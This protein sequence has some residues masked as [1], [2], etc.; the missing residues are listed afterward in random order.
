MS[1]K[2]RRYGP[3][4]LPAHKQRRHPVSCRLTDAE[5][6]RL[7]GLRGAVSRGEWLRLSALSK[8]PRIVPAL[9]KSAWSDLSRVAGNLNQISRHIN[10][11]GGSPSDEVELRKTLSQLSEQVSE[12]RRLLIGQ[13][14]SGGPDESEG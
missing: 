7:D 3:E 12:L 6:A 11:V 8:P 1:E 9:N 5:L 2:K 14:G 13:D 4:P 10:E